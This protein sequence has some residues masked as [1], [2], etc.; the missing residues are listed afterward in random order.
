MSTHPPADQQRLTEVLK[1]W[2]DGDPEAAEMALSLLYDDL[3][4][5]ARRQLRRERR[6]HTLQATALVHEAFLR[7]AQANNV[8]LQSRAHFASLLAGIMRRVL[9]DHARERNALKRRGK[10]VSVTLEEAVL[11]AGS[12][13]PDVLALDEA[14]VRLAARD[15]QK[16][17]IV[18]LRF[19]GGLTLDETAQALKTSPATVSRQW[20]L[21]RAWLFK[22]LGGA[23]EEAGRAG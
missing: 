3:R 14:L 8:H 6:G 22:E 9:I 15:A 20:R 19:F 21:A 2:S 23:P 18:E 10:R 1:R 11:E 5:M 4:E 7:L 16:A 17:R 12:Q 13:P